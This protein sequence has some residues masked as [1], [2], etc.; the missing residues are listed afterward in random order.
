MNALSYGYYDLRILLATDIL[1]SNS[2][3][4]L[5]VLAI[6]WILPGTVFWVAHF[7][8][9]SALM[10]ENFKDFEYTSSKIYYVCE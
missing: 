6:S 9:L 5:Q 2:Y 3:G 1:S 10:I 7:E 8:I 4:Q